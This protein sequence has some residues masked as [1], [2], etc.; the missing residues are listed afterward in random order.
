MNWDERKWRKMG[1]RGIEFCLSRCC[2]DTCHCI[3][4]VKVSRVERCYTQVVYFLCSHVLYFVR[5]QKELRK[6]AKPIYVY[7]CVCQWNVS[8]KPELYLRK[9]VPFVLTNLNFHYV[10]VW[11]QIHGETYI[12]GEQWGW[13]R[14]LEPPSAWKCYAQTSSAGHP[15]GLSPFF[16]EQTGKC[17]FQV[18][19]ASPSHWMTLLALFTDQ[20]CWQEAEIGLWDLVGAEG[21]EGKGVKNSYLLSISS[22]SFS[23][24]PFCT[25]T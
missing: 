20:G 6:H 17:P 24:L 5:K 2:W 3:F 18:Q 21:R 25:R 8:W 14:R 1:K 9:L 22:D 7:L 23:R 12:S 16:T 19:R 13:E 4:Q 11:A 15:S 10:L